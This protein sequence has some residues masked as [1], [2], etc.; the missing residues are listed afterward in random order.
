MSETIADNQITI[1]ETGAFIPRSLFSHETEIVETLRKAAEQS[2][3]TERQQ[4]LRVKMPDSSRE[5]R[6]IK[7]HRKEY[8]GQW[9]ALDGDRLLSHGMNAKEVFAAA[10]QSGVTDPFFAHL[11]PADALPFGGW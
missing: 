10:D 2:P 4:P 11:E 7:E 6:W 8:A 1:T 3:P 5:M 9:V